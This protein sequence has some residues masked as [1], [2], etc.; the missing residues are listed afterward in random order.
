M[1]DEFVFKVL[2]MQKT[3]AFSYGSEAYIFHTG[4][5]NDF[6]KKYGIKNLLRYVALV[7]NAYLSDSNRTPLGALADFTAENWKAVRRLNRY[8]LLEKFYEQDCGT[9]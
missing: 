8:A 3:Y 7:Q 2:Y 4:V 1:K 9:F 6:D 5:Y